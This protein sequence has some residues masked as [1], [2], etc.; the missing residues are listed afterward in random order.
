MR[1]TL[2][3]G[4]VYVW[5]TS[6]AVTTSR[7]PCTISANSK[8]TL[9]HEHKNFY[10]SSSQGKAPSG[11]P[12]VVGMSQV[13]WSGSNWKSDPP[14][15]HGPGRGERRDRRKGRRPRPITHSL[16][17]VFGNRS[18]ARHVAGTL[19]VRVSQLIFFPV[20]LCRK[21]L[22]VFPKIFITTLFGPSTLP[23]HLMH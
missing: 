12:L 20:S 17:P 21:A 9:A 15:G 5:R 3:G 16:G 23:L 13:L 22:R 8:N 2:A 6:L 11:S 7:V 4:V 18:L 1:T 19:K 10:Q 14:F